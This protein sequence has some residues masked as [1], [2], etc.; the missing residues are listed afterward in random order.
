MKNDSF[1]LF[2]MVIGLAL[3]MMVSACAGS[4]SYRTRPVVTERVLDAS[5]TTALN[6]NSVQEKTVQ[7]PAEGPCNVQ[8]DLAFNREIKAELPRK[9][10]GCLPPM[11]YA[12][13]LGGAGGAAL[14]SALYPNDV[15]VGEDRVDIWFDAT[16]KYAAMGAAGSAIL[17]GVLCYATR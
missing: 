6:G 16:W 7:C 15:E 1:N 3:A 10:R 12:G 11:V 8:W 17:T 13:L 4:N 2:C 9:K 5:D 14:G